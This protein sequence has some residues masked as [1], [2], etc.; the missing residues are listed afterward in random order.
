LD[1]GGNLQTVF[2]CQL[3]ITSLFAKSFCKEI[4]VKWGNLLTELVPE[5]KLN[6]F[7]TIGGIM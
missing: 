1:P 2:M 5:F 4:A 3:S 7:N 6:L